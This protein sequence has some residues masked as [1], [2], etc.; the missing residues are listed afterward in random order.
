MDRLKEIQ[1]RLKEIRSVLKSGEDCDVDDLENE[2]RE[3]QQE[4]EELE[5]RE[6]RQKVAEKITTGEVRAREVDKAVEE[7]PTVD[8]AEKRGKKLK[9]KRAV[10]VGSTDVILPEWKNDQIKPTFNEVSSLIDL[11]SIKPLIGGE[12]YESPYLKGYG[13]GGYT[14]E[15]GNPTEA[16]P[17]WG[18]ATI[19]KSKITAYAEDTEELQKLPAADYDGEVMKGISVA[20]RKKITKEILVGAGGTNAFV[21]IFDSNAEAIEDNTDIE[22]SEINED[23]LDDII[24]SFGGDEDV[25][26][27]AVLILNKKDLKV[28]ATLRDPNGQKIYDVQHNGNTG[29][30]D[31]VNYIINS[32]CK[33][34]TDEDTS[35]GDYCMAYGPL[36]NYEM[37]IFSD[38]DV[39]RSV[40]YKFKEGMIA[41][42]G[43]IFAGGNVVAHN[44]FLR[45]KKG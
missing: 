45:V 42:R 41:H 4:K 8:E 37:T 38:L 28:F 23:T 13:E 43:V 1:T 26:D 11:V 14:D 15:A 20:C 22:V 5:Q 7:T 6:K 2:I 3:L 32:A 10:T 19:S 17:T 34:I 24:F 31:G 27:A 21:G 25:E 29:S 18:Y 9:E 35:A 40:D 16:E 33:A 12:S 39:K 36:S 30:I 44:G